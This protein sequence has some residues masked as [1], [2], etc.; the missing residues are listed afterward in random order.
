MSKLIQ[1]ITIVRHLDWFRF[2]LNAGTN[3]ATANPWRT[4][5][6][7]SSEQIPVSRLP[8]SK[9]LTVF[10]ALRRIARNTSKKVAPVHTLQSMRVFCPRLKP[11][12]EVY[13]KQR[14][15]V[16]WTQKNGLS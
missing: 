1:P 3:A 2:L 14:H 15:A 4:A 13:M 16:H 5:F 11:T 10:K 8:L 7:M 6:I 12:L 9:S